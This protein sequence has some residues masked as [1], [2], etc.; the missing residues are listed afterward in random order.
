MSSQLSSQFGG[1]G[2]LAVTVGRAF[3][4]AIGSAFEIVFTGSGDA[5][6]VDVTVVVATAAVDL[7]IFYLGL[8]IK[9]IFCFLPRAF[10]ILPRDFVTVGNV[11]RTV[12]RPFEIAI[13]RAFWMMFTGK[14]IAV[15]VGTAT[16]R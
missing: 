14:G 2:I 1:V 13:G 8:A 9:T 6:E 4:R 15:D 7:L 12:G 11:A 16:V 3:E 10:C 5:I